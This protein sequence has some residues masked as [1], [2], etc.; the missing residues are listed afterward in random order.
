VNVK[1]FY[2][3]DAGEN[4]GRIITY[5]SKHK[6]RLRLKDGFNPFW[7][8]FVQATYWGWLHGLGQGLKSL[9][10]RMGP[11][12]AGSGLASKTKARHLS[13][14]AMSGATGWPAR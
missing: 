8:P 9:R 1:R 13:D 2:E 12:R 5:S 14:Q 4:A 10:I 6:M 11:M 3:G 7:P